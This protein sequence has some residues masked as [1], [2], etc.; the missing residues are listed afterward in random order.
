MLIMADIIIVTG[1]RN[2]GKTAYLKGLLESGL[3]SSGFLTV[4]DDA[5][6]KV[7]RLLDVE[8]GESRMLMRESGDGPDRIG[9]YAYDP[10]VFEWARER[11]SDVVS[12]TVVLDEIGRLELSGG[13]FD[14][15]LNTLLRKRILLYV[16]V[17]TEF[18]DEFRARYKIGGCRL[19]R[20]DG[21]KVGQGS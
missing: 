2:A 13:G 8:T 4:S 19:V 9:R 11:L 21:N 7:L 20:I 6:K 5:G 1:G 16:S 17:R 10:N 3:F 18:L 15:I 12:G 14:P